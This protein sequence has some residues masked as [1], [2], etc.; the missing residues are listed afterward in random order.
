[1]KNDYLSDCGFLYSLIEDLSHGGLREEKGYTEEMLI[2]ACNVVIE[3]IT[4]KY[5]G[6]ITEIQ[7]L[8]A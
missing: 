1:M 4:K 2:D 3:F 6:Q 7:N 5:P 8:L